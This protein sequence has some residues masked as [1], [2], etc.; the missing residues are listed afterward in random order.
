ME[1]VRSQQKRTPFFMP[2]NTESRIKRLEFLLSETVPVI[3]NAAHDPDAEPWQVDFRLDLLKRV[4]AELTREEPCTLT[5][6]KPSSTEKTTE[7]SS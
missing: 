5:A 6:P 4:K 7:P 3:Y 2:T 1:F